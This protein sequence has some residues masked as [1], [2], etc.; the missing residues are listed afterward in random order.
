MLGRVPFCL[1][2]LSYGRCGVV[3]YGGIRLGSVWQLSYGGI[4]CVKL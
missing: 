1:V 4:R 2:E 3:D